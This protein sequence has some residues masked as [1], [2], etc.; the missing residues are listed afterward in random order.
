MARTATV[1]LVLAERLNRISVGM[2]KEQVVRELGTPDTTSA[3]GNEEILKY[4][5]MT[6]V[7]GWGPEYFYVRLVDGKVESYGEEG[8]LRRQTMKAGRKRL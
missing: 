6:T 7:V 8:E 2:P 1:L 5:W 4:K 3:S